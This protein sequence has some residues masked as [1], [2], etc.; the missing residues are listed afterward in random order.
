M[1]LF[2]KAPVPGRVKTRLGI[3]PERAAALHSGF[4]RQALKLLESWSARPADRDAVLA[5]VVR[6]DAVFEEVTARRPGDKGIA[7][8]PDRILSDHNAVAPGHGPVG[9]ARH[10]A[11]TAEHDSDR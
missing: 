7:P 5:Q 6:W 3:D 11:V 1:I 2:A 10:D 4:V 8:E 9:G